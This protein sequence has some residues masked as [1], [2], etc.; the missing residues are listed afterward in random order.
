M[1]EPL[2]RQGYELYESSGS[3]PENLAQALAH[4]V[5]RGGTVDVFFDEECYRLTSCYA[6]LNSHGLVF[7]RGYPPQI[8]RLL[9]GQQ[10]LTPKRDFQFSISLEAH[11]K[12]LHG[13]DKKVILFAFTQGRSGAREVQVVLYPQDRPPLPST[14]YIVGWRDSVTPIFN[15]SFRPYVIS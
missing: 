11:S 12:L 13:S 5:F 7:R 8:K 1:T 10:L 14:L 15:G 3:A 4:P 2:N 9:D 6:E